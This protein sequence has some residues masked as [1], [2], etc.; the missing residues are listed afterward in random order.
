MVKVDNNVLLSIADNNEESTL[1][2]LC[3][4]SDKSRYT[5]V[6]VNI[7]VSFEALNLSCYSTNMAFFTI[8]NGCKDC[9]EST[10]CAQI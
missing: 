8:A 9:A 5:G 1:L 2:F 6:T 10:T 3:T 4:I 7:D